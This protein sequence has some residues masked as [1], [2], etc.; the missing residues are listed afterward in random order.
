MVPFAGI[1]YNSNNGLINTACCGMAD[2][3]K[4]IMFKEGSAIGCEFDP[5]QHLVRW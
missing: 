4:Q 1:L 2:I 5:G 3:L